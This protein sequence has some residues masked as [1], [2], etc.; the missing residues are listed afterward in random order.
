MYFSRSVIPY[1]RETFF[2]TLY[3]KHIMFYAFRK[4][5]LVKFKFGDDSTGNFRK[6]EA[7]R[8]LETE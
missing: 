5:A 3:Y 2:R 8:Y 1:P 6:I 4:E 7:I